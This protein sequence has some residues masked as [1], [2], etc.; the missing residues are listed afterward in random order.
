MFSETKEELE[1]LADRAA[2]G[3]IG[4]LETLLLAVREP[5]FNL[6]LRMLG[7]F[8]DAEDAAQ[9]ILLKVM[10]GL[11]SFEK[12][13]AFS[14][15]VFRVAVNYLI[16]YQKHMF[17]HAPLSFDIYAE[18]IEHAPMREAP[19]L[20]EGMERELLA[21]ELKMSCTNVMLQCLDA[22]SR[23]IFVLGTMF[24]LDSRIAGEVLSITP[25]A[26]RQRLSRA[27][28]RMADFLQRYCGAYGDGKCRCSERVNYAIASHRIDPMQRSFTA[29]APCDLQGMMA[30]KQAME[31]MDD[32]AQTF[33]FCKAYESP[34]RTRHFL[35]EVL[36]SAQLNAVKKG[37]EAHG[38]DGNA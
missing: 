9:E 8:A 13:S 24:R 26:Y 2:A 35:A 16:S 19:D 15:W 31:E 11:P 18:D 33:A 37:V 6:S 30:F 5:V 1:L 7:G 38:R 12:R 34:E 21:E 28:R 22:E 10:N 3:D 20:A 4:A 27:R 25:E 14:T 17:A 36:D 29:A 32:M 23:C